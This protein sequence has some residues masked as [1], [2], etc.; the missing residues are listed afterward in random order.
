[1]GNEMNYVEYPSLRSGDPLEEV[2]GCF[3]VIMT[4]FLKKELSM[5]L[6]YFNVF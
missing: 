5:R 2:N 1:M 3:L 4:S 6:N